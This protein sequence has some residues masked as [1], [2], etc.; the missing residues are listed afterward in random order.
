MASCPHPLFTAPTREILMTLNDSPDDLRLR[1]DSPDAER[2]AADLT[3]FL[4]ATFD[5]KAR[6]VANPPPS[7]RVL[8]GDP[9]VLAA[10]IL[11]IPGAVLAASDLVQ[12]LELKE[13]IDHLLEWA[14]RKRSEDG[15]RIE[16]L[17][18][19]DH[20]LPLDTATSEEVLE[21]TVRIVRRRSGSAP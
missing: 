10:L 12:R 2:L 13:K 11:A 8:R 9:M 20:A 3:D 5:A 19:D 14:R 7:G 6:R 1:V 18:A 16:L 17:D 4:A 21:I 15:S